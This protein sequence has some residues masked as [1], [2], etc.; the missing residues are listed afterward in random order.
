MFVWFVPG[1]VRFRRCSGAAFFLVWFVCCFRSRCPRNGRRYHAKYMATSTTTTQLLLFNRPVENACWHEPRRLH[2][3]VSGV[4]CVMWCRAWCPLFPDAISTC[5][6][7]L[8]AIPGLTMLSKICHFR[9]LL[10]R[11]ALFRCNGCLKTGFSV[12]RR[13]TN[14]CE[15]LY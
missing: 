5:L 10:M 12:Y 9:H 3:Y 15:N 6:M 13:T 2:R 7:C 4:L 14:R 1:I 11:L 8:M